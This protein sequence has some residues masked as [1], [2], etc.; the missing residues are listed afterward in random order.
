MRTPT[1]VTRVPK[2]GEGVKLLKARRTNEPN[3]GWLRGSVFGLHTYTTKRP[4]MVGPEIRL[5]SFVLVL[6]E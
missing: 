4:E 6:H 5:C 2:L 3:L 1:S